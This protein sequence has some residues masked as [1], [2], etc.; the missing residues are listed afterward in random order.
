MKLTAF[1]AHIHFAKIVNKNEY[2]I[3][4]FCCDSDGT[5]W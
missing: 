2:E 4:L 1:A 3:P 5:G